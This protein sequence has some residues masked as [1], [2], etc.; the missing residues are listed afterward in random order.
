[1]ANEEPPEVVIG[2]LGELLVQLRLWEYGVQAAP[3]I[4][5]SGNDLIA[6][7]RR[8]VRFIQVKT[9]QDPNKG[10][11]WPRL[12]T[13]YDYVALVQLIRDD[14]GGLLLDRCRIMFVHKSRAFGARRWSALADCELSR[15]LVDEM[16]ADRLA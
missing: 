1:M 13:E 4:K 15:D 3:P 14:E 2:T 6:I 10:P 8:E 7:R 16:F 5:D 9:T 12:S 11:S